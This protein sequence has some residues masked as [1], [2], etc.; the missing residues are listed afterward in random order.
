MWS[1]IVNFLS[2]DDGHQPIVA[3]EDEIMKISRGDRPQSGQFGGGLV[4][5]KDV[6]WPFSHGGTPQ[7]R[8]EE[9]CP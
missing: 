8:M 3:L 4:M 5:V 7:V 6:E 1:V 9:S 2:G